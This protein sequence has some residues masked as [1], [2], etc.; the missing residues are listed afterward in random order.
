MPVLT[1]EQERAVANARARFRAIESARQRASMATENGQISRQ[2][3]DL[4]ADQNP[5]GTYR[6]SPQEAEAELN[7]RRSARGEGPWTRYEQKSPGPRY[8]G[9]PVGEDGPWRRYQKA[10]SNP[11]DQFD[12]PASSAQPQ[13][14]E[15]DPRNVPGGLPG[16][17]PATGEVAPAPLAG[18]GAMD[19]VGAF[20]GGFIDGIPIAGPLL[21]EAAAAGVAGLISPFTDSTFSEEYQSAL[22]V[23][24]AAQEANPITSTVGSIGGAVAGTLPMVMAAPTAFG[25]GG[26]P[27]LARTGVSALTGTALGGADAAV[28]SGGAPEATE[29]GLFY[30]G[31]AGVA[32]PVAGNAIGA[33][34]RAASNIFR[35]NAMPGV[36]GRTQRMFTR[37]A[38]DDGLNASNAMIQFDRLGPEAMGIDLGTNL[39]RQ[40]AALAAEPGEAQR[41]VRDAILRRDA[42]ANA[43]IRGELDS[44]LG[45]AP[46]PSQVETGIRTN[47]RALSPM[48][49][50]VLRGARRVDT[51]SI[52]DNLD[53]LAVTLRGDAQAAVRQVRQMLNVT[54]TEQLDPDPA[55]LLAVRQAID[56]MM[57]AGT[58]GNNASRVIGDTRQA[59]DTELARAAPGIKEVDARFAELARQR[60]ALERGQQV[61][62]P[63]RN[64]VV[65]PSELQ[66][67][68]T[69]GAQPR[70]AMVGPSAVPVRI[71]E[72]ARAEL[73]RIVGTRGNDRVA[74]QRLIG[75]EG[76]WSP[77]HLATLFGPERARRILGVLD[78]EKT[79]AETSNRVLQN[80][81]TAARTAAREEIAPRATRTGNLGLLTAIGGLAGGGW[82]AAAAAGARGADKVISG[83]T[84][85]VGDARQ[86]ASNAGLAK[87]LTG[88]RDE[89]VALLM[90]QAARRQPMSPGVERVLRALIAGPGATQGQNVPL[91]AVPFLGAR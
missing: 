90:D 74:L 7:R 79:F 4:L 31:L 87:V 35:P 49:K 18:T 61:F 75:G 62:D 72:G 85:S 67:E 52:A 5:D 54:G 13:H 70:G 39:R 47:Q 80:S 16:Y 60:D 86:A 56:D 33:S 3:R 10:G 59:V 23:D 53:S 84:R 43:R 77:Q 21:K 81:E 26:G 1:R 58:L 63:G 42:A 14:Y 17:D 6:V 89:I 55:T 11:F 66:Q 76:D 9:R 19:K 24:R 36:P 82:G 27:L 8:P 32:G 38:T 73:D 64:Q 28:R 44:T 25:A 83:V 78:A 65:R 12:A 50:D 2:P 91:P 34:L 51:Q 29:A 20:T 57:E 68:V 48:Y 40:G 71:R 15:F 69:E 45:I 46:I 41:I 37:A 30:G 88:P 22:D